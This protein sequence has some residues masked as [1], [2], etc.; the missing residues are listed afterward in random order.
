MQLTVAPAELADKPVLRRLLELYKY[1]FSEFTGD[2]LDE[3]GLYGYRY[4]DHYW[5][6]PERLPFLVRVDGRLAGFALVRRRASAAGAPDELEMAEFFVLLKYRGKLIGHE[7]ANWL[8]DHIHGRW[9][10]RVLANN[11]PARA[12]W[13]SA[14]G[15][16]SD[17]RFEQT[18]DDDGDFVWTFSGGR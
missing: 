8:F 13:A 18:V 6:E 1:D 10:V 5:T 16:Y 12:F 9:R 15:R 14:I 3:H 17:G 4:L 2:D 11:L 7:A